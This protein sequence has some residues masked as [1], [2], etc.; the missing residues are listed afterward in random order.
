M[1]C[2]KRIE[3]RT[4]TRKQRVPLRDEQDSGRSGDQQLELLRNATC[5]A[6]VE[7]DPLGVNLNGQRQRLSLAVAK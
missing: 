6:I 3:C 1:R 7:K 5:R 2:A 4:N